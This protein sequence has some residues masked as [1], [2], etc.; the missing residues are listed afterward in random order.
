LRLDAEQNL[1]RKLSPPNRIWFIVSPTRAAQDFMKLESLKNF[2]PV[3]T[4]FL[5]R[6]SPTYVKITKYFPDWTRQEQG[7]SWENMWTEV[8]KDGKTLGPRILETFWAEDR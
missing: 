7:P 1:K 2:G 6:H 3:A 5:G 8:D 4:W